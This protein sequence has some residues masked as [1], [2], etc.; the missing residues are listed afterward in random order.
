MTFVI[1]ELDQKIQK[2]AGF[3]KFFHYRKVISF[4]WI[5]KISLIELNI[6]EKLIDQATGIVIIRNYTLDV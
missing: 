3:Y 4:F 2:G 6:L 5:S 1:P